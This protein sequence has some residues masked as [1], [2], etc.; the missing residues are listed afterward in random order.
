MNQMNKIKTRPDP[1][2]QKNNRPHELP[3]AVSLKMCTCSRPTRKYNNTRKNTLHALPTADEVPHET[4][5]LAAEWTTIP[6]ASSS[7]AKIDNS[8]SSRLILAS[9]F[10][11]IVS[12][13]HLWRWEFLIVRWFL[14]SYKGRFLVGSGNP[15]RV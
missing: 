2:K 3:P 7:R 12:S 14:P 11:E 5:V 13:E 6:V 8:S 15:G 1:G 4:S 9:S 10:I